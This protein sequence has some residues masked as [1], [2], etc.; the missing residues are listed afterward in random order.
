MD[1][2]KLI[3]LMPQIRAIMDWDRSRQ[4]WALEQ[5]AT[6]SRLLSS[7]PSSS[8]RSLFPRPSTLRTKNQTSTKELFDNEKDRIRSDRLSR[9]CGSW[10]NHYRIE[11]QANLLLPRRSRRLCLTTCRKA[12]PGSPSFHRTAKRLQ[13]LSCPRPISLERS[14]SQP[15]RECAW[16]PP[17]RLTPARRSRLA[18]VK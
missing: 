2:A 1:R 3:R 18:E 10:S 12:G 6:I 14:L 5:T 11:A 13:L 16:P 17:L 4:A 7:E 15:Y 9:K 8:P